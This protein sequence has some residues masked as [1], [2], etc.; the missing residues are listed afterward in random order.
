MPQPSLGGAAGVGGGVEVLGVHTA[1]DD[2]DLP[3]RD[4]HVAEFHDLVGAGGQDPFAAPAELPFD[5]DALV[6][7]GVPHALVAPLDGAEGVEGLDEGD[8][9]R[10]RADL[11]GHAGHPEVGVHDVGRS[12][13]QARARWAPKAGMC[14]NSSSL[15][16][17]HGWSAEGS[18]GY[19]RCR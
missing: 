1:G 8:A 11:R 19:L 17:G 5:A 15:R 2:G 16:D 3:G 6:G 9:V 12:R 10:A 13:A 4:A 7:A 18:R 14:G